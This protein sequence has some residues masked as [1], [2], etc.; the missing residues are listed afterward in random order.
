MDALSIGIINPE[1]VYPRGAEKQICELTYHLT[2]MGHKV[3]IYTFEKSKPY[4]FDAL[5]KDADI[6][7]LDKPWIVGFPFRLG[8][9]NFRWLYL[10]KKLSR[11]LKRHDILNAY[12]HPAQWISKF[13]EI[14]TI[15]TCNEPPPWIYYNYLGIKKAV[16]YPYALLDKYLSSNINLILSLDS[17]MQKIIKKGYMDKKVETLGSGASLDR[18]IKH[19]CDNYFDILFVGALH[20]Q[21]RP[22]DIILALSLIK[23]KI[24]NL[25]LHFVGDGPLRKEIQS[26]ACKNKLNVTLYGSISNE[27]LYE[28]YAIA[29]LAVFVPELQP[30]GIFPLEAILAG[31]PTI[32]SDQCGIQDILPK[33]FPIVKTGDVKQLSRKILEVIERHGEYKRK[34]IQISK[35]I[36]EKYSWEAYAKRLINVFKNVVRKNQ[37]FVSHDHEQDV[38]DLHVEQFAPDP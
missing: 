35:V 26:L 21:K 8:T 22:I 37:L 14:T 1:L 30:W 18:K 38:G 27:K 7:S 32:I 23:E 12:N 31:V 4:I 10:I 28:L 17:L 2:K 20:P 6:V 9:F 33:D 16:W 24:P 11:R 13:T 19:K 34:T 15:W 5:L 25:K 3:T 36:K 29:D